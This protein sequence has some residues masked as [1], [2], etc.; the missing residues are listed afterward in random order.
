MHRNGVTIGIPVYNEQAFIESA[1]R[2]AAPQCE[3][4][5]ISENSSTDNSAAICEAL[6]RDYSNAVCV[7]QQTNIGAADNFKF[8]LEQTTTPYF[9]W[10]GGHDMI[11]DGYV[12]VL[13]QALDDDSSAVLAFGAA[14]HIAVGD[15]ES[16]RYEYFYSAGL[17][18]E[19]P[20]VRLLTLI[21]FLSD[22]S[23]VHGVFRTN[24][25]KNAWPAEKCLGV[26][27]ILLAKAALVGKF[28]YVPETHLIRRDAHP[29]DTTEAQLVRIT[30]ESA[31][32]MEARYTEMQR[33]LFELSMVTT[34][35][36]GLAGLV[37]LLKAR[38]YLVSGFGPFAET[39]PMR[40]LEWAF[41]KATSLFRRLM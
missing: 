18:D 35:S 39:G 12:S 31:D 15:A 11:P 30:G 14:R 34:K 6:C 37:F 36:Q 33:K 26:D 5:R 22:C 38:Y 41:C 28:V 17:A 19:S 20:T 16:L 7:R 23:L 25:L 10:L 13:K 3:T 27:H 2:S 32:G 21:R 8:L 9:M 40:G 24:V 29:G 4:L 1:I